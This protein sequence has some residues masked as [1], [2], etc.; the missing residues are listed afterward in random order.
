MHGSNLTAPHL[1]KPTPFFCAAQQK[2]IPA[3]MQLSFCLLKVADRDD[4]CLRIPI[5]SS[6]QGCCLSGLR[7][8]WMN[9]IWL[10]LSCYKKRTDKVRVT[11]KVNGSVQQLFTLV[12]TVMNSEKK[13]RFCIVSV[14]CP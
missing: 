1:R 9:L 2:S 7:W 3:Y 10:F 14:N 6:F 13:T 12:G 8:L 5:T 4:V 11:Q